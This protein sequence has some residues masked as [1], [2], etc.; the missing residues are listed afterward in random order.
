MPLLLIPLV[1]WILNT[2]LFVLV[3]RIIIAVLKAASREIF[4]RAIRRAA[5]L[6]KRQN[7]RFNREQKRTAEE[8]LREDKLASA[9]RTKEEIRSNSE[10]L[11]EEIASSVIGSAKVVEIAKKIAEQVIKAAPGTKGQVLR[12]S[13]RKIL[14]EEVASYKDSKKEF[15]KEVAKTGLIFTVIG[16]VG[17][18]LDEIKYAIQEAIPS[19]VWD[20][21]WQAGLI[22]VYEAPIPGLESTFPDNYQ[23]E[24]EFQFPIATVMSIMSEWL[25]ID[26]DYEGMVE[27]TALELMIRGGKIAKRKRLETLGFVRPSPRTK[28]NR[29]EGTMTVTLRKPKSPRARV[30]YARILR[31]F[32]RRLG[33]EL[34]ESAFQRGKYRPKRRRRASTSKRKP[35]PISAARRRGIPKRTGDLRSTY[36]YKHSRGASNRRKNVFIY[37]VRNKIARWV[38]GM[39]DWLA[40]SRAIVKRHIRRLVVE[41]NSANAQHRARL[42]AQARIRKAEAQKQRARARYDDIK[43][44]TIRGRVSSFFGRVRA[45][46]KRTV[47]AVVD[48]SVRFY[49]ATGIKSVVDEI[50]EGL[51]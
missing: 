47:S 19:K 40:F 12:G 46:G 4:R 22:D 7:S 6:R 15:F 37:G 8:Q 26:T 17:T 2:I 31:K 9:R 41:Q 42:R 28:I 24:I 51:R 38:P 39:G 43:R 18:Y 23:G 50:R 32:K 49:N 45:I 20:W 3:R 33:R 5:K 34:K 11:A 36:Y 25:G 1:A 44:R 13:W 27:D 35:S 48:F 10:S 29:Q 21:L 30:A 16:A 14:R